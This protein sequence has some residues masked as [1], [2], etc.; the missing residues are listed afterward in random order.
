MNCSELKNFIINYGIKTYCNHFINGCSDSCIDSDYECQCEC[1][2]DFLFCD[3][4]KYNDGVKT[5]L[6]IFYICI[7]VIFCTFVYSCFI[8]KK[9]RQNQISTHQTDERQISIDEQVP[10]YEDNQPPIYTDQPPPTYTTQSSTPKNDN[11]V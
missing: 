2:H 9:N 4:V 6:Y 11:I 5:I 7:I 8:H 1:Q 10:M 3:I